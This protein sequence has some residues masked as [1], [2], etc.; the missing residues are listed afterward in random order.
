[1]KK[2]VK[3]LIQFITI[4]LMAV[5][6]GIVSGKFVALNNIEITLVPA[7]YMAQLVYT[8]PIFMPNHVGGYKPGGLGNPEYLERDGKMQPNTMPISIAY[9]FKDLINRAQT[10]ITKKVNTETVKCS[11]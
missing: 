2:D 3:I 9:G 5:V 8:A 1:M 7:G 6:A 11:T 10:S 4:L